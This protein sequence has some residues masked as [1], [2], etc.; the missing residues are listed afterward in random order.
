MSSAEVRIGSLTA[1]F[2]RTA[3]DYGRYRA[4]FPPRFFDRLRE[5]GLAR[6][7]MRA[8]DLGTG[9]GSIARGLARLGC[10]CVGLDG[11][12]LLTEAAAR[13]DREAGVTVRYVEMPA[14][15]TGSPE[16]SFYLITAGEC[17]DW[18]DRGRARRR[19][20]ACR[21]REGIS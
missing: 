15:D 16:G 19:R 4:G 3:A 9:T 20:T 12:R 2:G 7:G 13:L 6:A 1:D 18:F 8:L 10:D 5:A 11:S 17:R 21:G 14:D